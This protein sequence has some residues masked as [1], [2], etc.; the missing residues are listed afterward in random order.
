MKKLFYFWQAKF[1]VMNKY[2]ILIALFILAACKQEKIGYVDTVRLMENS[3][4]KKDIESKYQVKSASWTKKRDSISQALQLEAQALQTKVQSMS[5]TKAQEEYDLF[6][7][8]SQFMGQQLQQ[9]EQMLQLQGQAEM[10]SLITRVRGKITDYGKKNG[11]TYILDG[12]Q[13]GVVLYGNDQEDLTD[14][15]IKIVNDSY[16]K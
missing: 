16:E 6:Q 14:A 9:E 10:D 4:E 8:K 2:W 11:F 3:E 13:G 12:G 15:F 5:Q 7:Q 1:L